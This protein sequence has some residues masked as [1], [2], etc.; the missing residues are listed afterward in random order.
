MRWSHQ[1]SWRATRAP[2]LAPP[3]TSPKTSDAFA[4]EPCFPSPSGVSAICLSAWP[5]RCDLAVALPKF[6]V[7]IATKLLSGLESR[8]ILVAVEQ[9]CFYEETVPSDDINAIVS[10]PAPPER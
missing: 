2:R 6:D 4:G 9:N 3:A 10:H 5:E 1:A 8:G 7:V